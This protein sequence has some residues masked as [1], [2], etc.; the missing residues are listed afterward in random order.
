MGLRSIQ[1]AKA[2]L[3]PEYQVNFLEGA[4][5]LLYHRR[6]EEQAVLSFKQNQ[7]VKINKIFGRCVLLCLAFSPMGLRH[8]IRGKKRSRRQESDRSAAWKAAILTVI[9][10]LESETRVLFKQNAAR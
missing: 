7:R 1:R 9:P 2:S 6:F 5:L 10:T 3:R 8:V 4:I